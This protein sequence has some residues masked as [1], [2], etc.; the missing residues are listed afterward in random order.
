MRDRRA[1]DLERLAALH[2]SSAI[3]EDEFA[4]LK[5]DVIGDR[6][7]RWGMASYLAVAVVAL[8]GGVAIG[9]AI[10]RDDRSSAPSSPNTLPPAATTVAAARIFVNDGT[11]MAPT[12]DAGDEVI[13]SPV[14]APIERGD[15]VVAEF[16]DAPSR[17]ILK[18][19]VALEGETIEI[20]DCV[21]LIDGTPIEE[22]YLDPELV[23]QGTCGGNVPPTTVP[24]DYVFVMGDNRAGSQD[25]RALGPIALNDLVGV[26]DAVRVADGD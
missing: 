5:S 6:P 4:R 14:D 10:G 20:A 8:A 2:S 1:E 18:R 24:D 9:W 12:L 11:S 21:V 16:G 7:G 15:L 13:V 25:S 23:V 3:S 22:P 19:V 17:T 26:V